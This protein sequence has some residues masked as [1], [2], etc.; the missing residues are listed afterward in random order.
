MVNQRRS[1]FR[2]TPGSGVTAAQVGASLAGGFHGGP[3]QQSAPLPGF[4]HAPGA[5]SAAAAPKDGSDAPTSTGKQGSKRRNAKEIAALVQQ[6]R[7]ALKVR[8][9]QF[10]FPANRVGV[11][12]TATYAAA[13]AILE[14]SSCIRQ[15]TLLLLDMR[16]LPLHCLLLTVLA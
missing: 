4:P 16:F 1:S 7:A 2:G 11:K 15:E 10:P 14:S 5:P 13:A 3:L 9:L 6:R 12:A 8:S